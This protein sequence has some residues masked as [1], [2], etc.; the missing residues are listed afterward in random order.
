MVPVS[1]VVA[2][3][4]GPLLPGRY[5]GMCV[6][7]AGGTRAVG[8]TPADLNAV[9]LPI[10]AVSVGL[11]SFPYPP[12]VPYPPRPPGIRP[13]PAILRCPLASISTVGST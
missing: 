11:S 9:G 3:D 4:G 8:P 10:S 5:T 13:A 7:A 12:Y 1:T 6:S 2:P